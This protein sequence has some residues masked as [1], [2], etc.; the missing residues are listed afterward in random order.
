MGQMRC[1][2]VEREKSI[3]RHF[4]TPQ[5]ALVYIASGRGSYI[6]DNGYRYPLEGGSLFQRLPWIPHTVEFFEPTRQFYI[7]VPAPAYALLRL[8]LPDISKQPVIT[9]GRKPAIRRGFQHIAERLQ[10]AKD[11]ALIHVLLEM[12]AFMARLLVP[13]NKRQKN[14]T[15]AAF[16]STARRL[17]GA[18]LQKKICMPDMAAQM[19]MSFSDF[20]QKFRLAA[21]VAPKTYRLRRRIETAMALLSGGD[22]PLKTI[23][24]ELGYRDLYAFSA[25]FKKM[26]GLAPSVYRQLHR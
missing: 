17:L 11:E 2:S 10:T 13:D 22:R 26:T 24:L 19:N 15:E 3:E 1:G 14:D 21:G 9:I 25:Q 7:A 8:T 6:A 12:T 20:R 23:A 5:F 4:V 16:V 18:D